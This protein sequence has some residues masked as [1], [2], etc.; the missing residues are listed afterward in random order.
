MVRSGINATN[1]NL[2]NPIITIRYLYLVVTDTVSSCVSVADTVIITDITNNIIA[3]IQDPDDL[4]LTTARSLILMRWSLLRSE[5][6]Y[7]W[8]DEGNIVEDLFGAVSDSGTFIFIVKSIS[9]CF[10]DDTVS[11]MI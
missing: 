6:I 1:D 7:I 9:G 8:T 4:T 2:I 3:V 5:Y 10:D 11:L